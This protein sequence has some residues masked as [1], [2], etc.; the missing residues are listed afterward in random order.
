MA[1]LIYVDNSNLYIEARRVSAVARGMAKDIFDAM[2]NDILDHSYSIDF[3]KLY[4]FLTGGK[5]A[6]VK[7]CYL[8]GSRPPPNDT[9]W[10]IARSKGFNPV[11]E[12]RNVAGKE[13]KIDTGIVTKMMSDGYKFADKTL[14]TITLVAGDSDYVRTIEQLR[15]DGYENVESVFW[16]HTSREL[17]DAVTSFTSL[18]SH[19]DLLRL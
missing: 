11:V 4:Q 15:E 12:N 3:G 18:N 10:D 17:K 1:E 9:L 2:D 8:F 5:D 6:E 19:L 13:K 14:D 16:N 7:S